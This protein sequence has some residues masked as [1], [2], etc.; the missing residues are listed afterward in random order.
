MVSK[1]ISPAYNIMILLV[2]LTYFNLF[3]FSWTFKDMGVSLFL[4]CSLILIKPTKIKFPTFG[5]FIMYLLMLLIIIANFIANGFN[6]ISLISIRFLFVYLLLILAGFN[7]GKYFT[8]KKMFI[9]IYIIYWFIILVGLFEWIDPSYVHLYT[10]GDNLNALLRSGLGYGLGSIFGDRVIF[11]FVLVYFLIINRIFIT[12][13]LMLF[14]LQLIIFSLIILTLSKTAIFTAIVI[15]LLQLLD[16]MKSKSNILIK[17]FFIV[18]LLVSV[19]FAISNFIDV[20]NTLFLSIKSAD[21]GNLSGRTENWKNL[22]FTILPNFNYI[23]SSTLLND[24]F[25]VAVDSAFL[26]MLVNF[27]LLMIM[28]IIII[29]I[30]FLKNWKNLNQTLKY[31]LLM[32]TFYSITVDFYHIVIVV[33]PMW[34]SIGF[35]LYQLKT[36]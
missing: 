6:L 11:G 5:F 34:F 8:E 33:V 25:N 31:T 19:F 22:D 12:S 32:L 36:K 13:M 3:S 21:F 26:R 16:Y 29:I 23:G 20:V 4:I 15:I 24:R 2:F 28:P 35:Y 7:V 9:L 14:I 30:E 1:I 10:V 17:A 27:G 18:F